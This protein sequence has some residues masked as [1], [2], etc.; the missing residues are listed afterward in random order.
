[1][2]ANIQIQTDPL[3]KYQEISTYALLEACGII[4]YW[5]AS[6]DPKQSLKEVLLANYDY[7][8]GEMTGGTLYPNG[9]YDY[10]EDPSLFPLVSFTK[11]SE[12]CFIYQYGMVGISTSNGETWVTRMD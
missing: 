8:S 7:Y 3:N 2:I 1:M 6:C 12:V 9:R 10:P 4:P 11:D 5:I